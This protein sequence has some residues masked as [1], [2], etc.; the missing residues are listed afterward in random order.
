MHAPQADSCV[1]S[2][3]SGPQAAMKSVRT[4]RRKQEERM[5][6]E[7]IRANTYG[8]QAGDQR[9]YAPLALRPCIFRTAATS[10]LRSSC[11]RVSGLPLRLTASM[12]PRRKIKPAALVSF[13][14]CISK[15]HM[16]QRHHEQCNRDWTCSGCHSLCCLTHENPARLPIQREFGT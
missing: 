1:H 9:P 16:Q 13:M 6:S 10:L 8:M 2:A 7:S 14:A 3:S 15:R 12:L 4:D 11:L 5:I